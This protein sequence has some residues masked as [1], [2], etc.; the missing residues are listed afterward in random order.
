MKKIVPAA[1]PDAYVKSLRGWQHE[2]VTALR[3]AV[4]S[5]SPLTEEIKW[6]HLVYS[7]EG[8][9][10][11]IRAEKDKKTK[12]TGIIWRAKKLDS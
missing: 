11:L 2:C 1:N 6:G 10:L 3:K 7:A 5:V 4:L 12:R 9:V 8:P